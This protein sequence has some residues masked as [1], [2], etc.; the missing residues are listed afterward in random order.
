MP[1]VKDVMHSEF[2]KLVQGNHNSLFVMRQND[3]IG[4]R[5]FKG[6]SFVP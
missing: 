5:K 4:M 6:G 1:H 3:I 2:R